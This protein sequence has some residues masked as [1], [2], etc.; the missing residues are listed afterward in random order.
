MLKPRRSLKDLINSI[1]WQKIEPRSG[2][3]KLPSDKISVSFT[4]GSKEKPHII[5]RINVRIGHDILNVMEWEFKEKISF[6][7]SPDDYRYFMLCKA[8]NG[9]GYRLTRETDLRTGA[10][11]VKWDENQFNGHKLE[12]ASAFLVEHEIY[13]GYL[14]FKAI[15]L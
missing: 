12:K 9:G 8:E 1:D 10:I 14:A 11:K 15:P 5:D 3:L 6:Y 4:A 13:E 7:V 2:A